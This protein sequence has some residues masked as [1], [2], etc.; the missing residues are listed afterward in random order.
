[1]QMSETVG[2]LAEALAAAQSEMGAV[3]EEEANPFYSSTY[4]GLATIIKATAPVL[5]AHGLAV[6]QLPGFEGDYDVLTTTVLHASGE[7][8]SETMRLRPVKNDPQAQGSAIT[9]A[10]R[11]AYSA[12]TGVVTEK[13]DDGNK[14][15][16]QGR[17]QIPR[18][19]IPAAAQT[20]ISSSTTPSVQ[21]SFETGEIVPVDETMEERR[22]RVI[23]EAKAR[24]PLVEQAERAQA[25]QR[26]RPSPRRPMP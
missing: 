10:R 24:G 8:I 16:D 3:K 7:W 6:V 19:G 1:M 15:S 21:P 25:A 26:T 11:Y 13:D 23:A 17:P 5:T 18:G 22:Q 2:Q 4:A 12:A 9:Y 14:A 20:S